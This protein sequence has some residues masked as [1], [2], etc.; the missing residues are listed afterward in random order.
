MNIH[1]Y[2]AKAVLR[3]FGLPVSRGVA[4]HGFAL[5]VQPALGHFA[6][7]RPCGIAD[8]SVTSIAALLGRRLDLGALAA[9]I[10]ECFGQ[11]F[12]RA[13]VTVPPATIWE[14]AEG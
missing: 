2:Q 8:R 3:E 6:L 9:T 14:A 7:I 11:V 13:M 10:A 4:M 1:E 12:S 5:N